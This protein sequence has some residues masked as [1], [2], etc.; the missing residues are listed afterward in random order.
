MKKDYENKLLTE[1]ENKAY[2]AYCPIIDQVVEADSQEEREEKV[3]AII[4]EQGK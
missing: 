2:R 4:T 1:R 3:Q